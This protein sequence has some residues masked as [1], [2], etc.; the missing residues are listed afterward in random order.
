MINSLEKIEQILPD[1]VPN[2]LFGFSFLSWQGSSLTYAESSWMVFLI[3]AL[4]FLSCLFIFIFKDQVR[5]SYQNNKTVVTNATQIIGIFLLSLSVFR[6]VILAVGGYPNLWELIP[7][8][9][10]RIFVVL[11]G[12]SLSIR[13]M[14]LVKYFGIFAIGGGLMGLMIPDLSNSEYWSEFGGMEIG[15]DN[16][17]FWDYFII[18]VSSIILP[19]YLFTCLKPVFYKSEIVYTIFIMWIV[20]VS[21]FLLNLALSNV[22]DRRWRANWFYLGILE[23]NG[24]DEMLSPYLGPLVSYPAILF[25]FSIIGIIFYLGFTF[26]YINSDRIQFILRNEK[27]ND[28]IFRIK[29]IPSENMERFVEGPLKYREKYNL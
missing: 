25:T 16:Y 3:Y 27:T 29:I 9:F 12:I 17:V 2:G 5:V 22:G 20:T 1:R 23:I 28:F 24:I 11:I 13:K 14:E 10:C 18:H 15:I 19:V 26:L 4:V 8:H 7:L 21:I 6:I